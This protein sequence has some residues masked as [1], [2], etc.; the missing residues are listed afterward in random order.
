[1]VKEYVLTGTARSFRDTEI[2]VSKTDKKGILSYVNRTFIHISDYREAEL[3]GK[4]HN[5]IRHPDM[6]RAVFRLM[7]ERIQG[8]REIFAYVVNRCK[9]GD[10]YWVL[11]HVTPSFDAGGALC[12]FHSNR[13]RPDEDIVARQIVPLYA[14]MRRLEREA[15]DPRLGMDQSLAHLNATL[16]A[17]GLDYDRFFFA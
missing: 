8:G 5:I 9:N 17:K 15:A 16:A 12:G 13:R 7:W 10:H 2:I 6:P 1:M 4:P 14:E 3:L 11:A